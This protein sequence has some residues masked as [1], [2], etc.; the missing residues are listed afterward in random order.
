MNITPPIPKKGETF[1]TINETKALSKKLPSFL[2]RLMAIIQIVKY[3]RDAKEE[4]MYDWALYLP[5]WKISQTEKP[6]FDEIMEATLSI[7]K[8]DTVTEQTEDSD[9]TLGDCKVSIKKRHLMAVTAYII[10]FGSNPYLGEKFYNK[11][12]ISH[13]WIKKY[14]GV[15]DRIFA[16]DPSKSNLPDPYYQAET[17][18]R[19]E[20]DLNKDIVELLSKYFIE[21]NLQI[22]DKL[23]PTLFHLVACITT[24]GIKVTLRSNESYTYLLSN[25]KYLL[26]SS[27][28][29]IGVALQATRNNREDLFLKNLSGEIME[30]FPASGNKR[31]DK[32]SEEDF[33][34][35]QGMHIA[36]P[37]TYV[38]EEY[39]KTWEVINITN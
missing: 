26:D 29:I 3:I 18:S 17:I 23:L 11:V 14:F 1:F 7:H 34:L 5:S 9:D 28:S 21:G 38:E 24:K 4:E 32:A 37:R 22:I 10:C 30:V 36:I 27:Y 12:I 6:H 20:S 15:E 39:P 2:A 33:P 8:N 16:F 31:I 35:R 19:W 25:G 13:D